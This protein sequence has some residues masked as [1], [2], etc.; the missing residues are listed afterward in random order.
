M[1]GLLGIP[2][3]ASTPH[4]HW[5]GPVGFYFWAGLGWKVGIT[6][7]GIIF[8]IFGIFTPVVAP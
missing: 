6:L 3:V 1:C 4:Q 8:G 2:G 5:E 7:F